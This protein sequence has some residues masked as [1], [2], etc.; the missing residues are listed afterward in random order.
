MTMKIKSKTAYKVV[1]WLFVAITV[2]CYVW[3]L[4]SLIRAI[5]GLF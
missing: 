1:F 4:Y 3:S 2:I 5:V